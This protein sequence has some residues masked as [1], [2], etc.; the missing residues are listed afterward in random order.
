MPALTRSKSRKSRVG[1]D[2]T[3]KERG[4]NVA[5]EVFANLGS[6]E[7]CGNPA[8]D[9]HHKDGN[10]W[11]NAVENIEV[12]CRPCHTRHHA[13][14]TES[15]NCYVCGRET[16]PLRKLMCNACYERERR[17]R[18]KYRRLAEGVNVNE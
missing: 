7:R 3:H 5:R 18:K 10:T 13:T 4:R 8:T 12:L 9:R 11:N 14:R 16:K 17:G 6:C 1:T 2:Y 15:V